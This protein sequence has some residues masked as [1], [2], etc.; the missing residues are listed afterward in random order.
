MKLLKP[1]HYKNL[2]Q[3]K[4]LKTQTKEIIKAWSREN[5][6]NLDHNI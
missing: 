6:K 4:L 2:Q 1:E 5:N 3:G